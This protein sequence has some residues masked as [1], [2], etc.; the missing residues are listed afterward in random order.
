MWGGGGGGQ[1]KNFCTSML[2]ASLNILLLT[3]LPAVWVEDEEAK[4]HN[5]ALTNGT[6]MYSVSLFL[7]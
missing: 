1:G 7:A 2:R 4:I 3:S 5:D 6:H